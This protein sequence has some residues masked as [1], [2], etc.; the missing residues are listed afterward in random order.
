MLLLLLLLG[1]AAIA[2]SGIIHVLV[3]LRFIHI[4][5][6]SIPLHLAFTLRLTFR[7]RRKGC[8]QAKAL[9]KIFIVPFLN[10]TWR[11]ITRG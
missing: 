8:I 9:G 4:M 5:C 11:K 7:K 1:A 6:V 2:L 3:L 10:K